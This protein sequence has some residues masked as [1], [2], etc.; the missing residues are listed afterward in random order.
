MC[1]IKCPEDLFPVLEVILRLL[2]GSLRFTYNW[3][4]DLLNL[5]L[6]ITSV[7]Q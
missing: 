1:E 7:S 2:I 4:E 5:K 3:S 6:K